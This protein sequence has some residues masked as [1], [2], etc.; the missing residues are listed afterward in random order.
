MKIDL[1]TSSEA[2]KPLASDSQ[3]MSSESVDES[4]AGFFDHLS[5]LMSADETE[6]EVDITNEPASET[7]K[8]GDKSL[9]VQS[10][11]LTPAGDRD[12]SNQGNE[13]SGVDKQSQIGEVRAVTNTSKTLSLETPDYQDH[14]V[15]EV[16]AAVTES[17]ELLERLNES[18]RALQS[19]SEKVSSQSEQAKDATGV[20]E[21]GGKVL[22]L[23]DVDAMAFESEANQLVASGAEQTRTKSAGLNNW[24][25]THTDG[26]HADSAGLQSTRIDSD[27]VPADEF[28]SAQALS[29]QPIASNSQS[30][31]ADSSEET[32][33]QSEQDL[34]PAQR[35]IDQGLEQDFATK[36]F[37][38][39]DKVMATAINADESAQI[40]PLSGVS[41]SSPE[42]Q[43]VEWS[44]VSTL[45][46]SPETFDP[47]L[48]DIKGSGG[49][50]GMDVASDEIEP[51]ATHSQAQNI[52][53]QSP[54][55]R[56]VADNNLSEIPP[57][58]EQNSLATAIPWNRA[59]HGEGV[60]PQVHP[61]ADQVPST[62]ASVAANKVADTTALLNAQMVPA[63][64]VPGVVAPSVGTPPGG[65]QSVAEQESILPSFQA[66]GNQELSG[67]VSAAAQNPELLASL[68]TINGSVM[69]DSTSASTT[70]T[71]QAAESAVAAAMATSGAPGTARAE[72]STMQGN[73]V[74]SQAMNSQEMADKVNDQVQLM[75]SKNLKNIDIR[76]DPPELGRMQIRMNMNGDSTSVHF[77][78][79]NAQAREVLDQSMPRLREM[80]AQ[81]G[82][83]LADT[84]VSQQSSQQ[85]GRSAGQGEAGDTQQSNPNGLGDEDNDAGQSINLNVTTQQD[86]ISYYA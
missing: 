54:T 57:V 5:S 11:D 52:M 86:G 1:A 82:I 53:Q 79:A 71:S 26:T 61:V 50:H 46:S 44:E 51:R 8:N 66:L 20:A 68:G 84:S 28:Y 40:K 72:V 80:F 34:A 42:H 4:A 36:E 6:A 85:Q 38:Y 59:A 60:A 35:A 18:S 2:I 9:V 81:Q 27:I 15:Q 45:D 19:D 32:F 58:S 75:L 12:P 69:T 55:E 48:A 7:L 39:S 49:Q 41:H 13:S 14:R 56:S 70:A 25:G 74:I 73:M 3:P 37:A 78:V 30:T 47:P 31:M 43:A 65:A 64:S 33:S 21:Q 29:S 22:P 67:A 77:T 24:D 23:G 17:G 16:K 83:Q 62:P 10:E 76:L 63:Q